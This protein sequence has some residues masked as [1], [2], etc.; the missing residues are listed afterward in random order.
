MIYKVGDIVECL[1]GFKHD[2]DCNEY[3]NAQHDFEYGGYGYQEYRVFKIS[4]IADNSIRGQILFSCEGNGGVFANAVKKTGNFLIK[5]LTK[6]FD[7]V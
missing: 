3:G 7:F 4:R 2:W 6:T 1:P 5:K